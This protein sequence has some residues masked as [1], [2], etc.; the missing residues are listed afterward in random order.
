MAFALPP[1]PLPLAPAGKYGGPSPPQTPFSPQRQGV[2][3][4]GT[5]AGGGA[6]RSARCRCRPVGRPP[7]LVASAAPPGDGPA[8]DDWRAFRARLVAAELAPPTTGAAP[9][10]STAGTGTTAGGAAGAS[11]LPPLSS[12]A[13]NWAHPLAA[14]ET[15]C[16]LVATPG[17]HP[18]R[19]YFSHS[20]V[21][22]LHAGADGAAGVLLGR[23]AV[24]A[25]A[26]AVEALGEGGNRGGGS[27]GA[28]GSDDSGGDS[29]DSGGGGGGNS[30]RRH[31]L[32]AYE[33]G[34][35]GRSSVALLL[36]DVAGVTGS[37]PILPGLYVG[38]GGGGAGSDPDRDSGGDGGG[39][40]GVAAAVAAVCAVAGPQTVADADAVA[41]LRL[42]L[43]YCGWSAGQLEEEL[44]SGAWFVAA[45]GKGVVFGSTAGGAKAGSL[46]E[47]GGGS[48]AVDDWAVREAD[49]LASVRGGRRL[50][51]EVLC[52]MGG[53][54]KG[55]VQDAQEQEWKR[56]WEEGG[57]GE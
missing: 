16:L 5:S 45:A 20:V 48:D 18:P 15:G 29:G 57:G 8:D 41:R 54:Y 38:G 47:S 36:H 25:R 12:P 2:R 14:P 32:C 22:L 51:E 23:P 49:W 33:G 6:L 1:S 42:H 10:P 52:R 28:D 27:L 43:G 34:P 26:R 55:V 40:T 11:P 19:S 21:L 13:D 31:R 17:G 9:S 4:F 39:V 30:P 7:P 37:E 3:G 56:E 24:G 44:Q 35:V 46:E 50:W 53:P